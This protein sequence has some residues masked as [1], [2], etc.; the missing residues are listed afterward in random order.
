MGSESSR[1]E[2]QDTCR[3]EQATV[4]PALEQ[5]YGKVDQGEAGTEAQMQHKADK[6]VISQKWHL[7]VVQLKAFQGSKY[8]LSEV[9]G[10]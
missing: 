1:E 3:L 9:V 2:R 8:S 7:Q 6:T 5:A 10:T 4:D